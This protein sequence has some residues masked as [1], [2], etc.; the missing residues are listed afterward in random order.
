MV[1]NKQQ[2]QRQRQHQQ[3]QYKTLNNDICI[4]NLDL[5]LPENPRTNICTLV[6]GCIEKKQTNKQTQNK[7]LYINNTNNQNN[8]KNPLIRFSL[9]LKKK[10]HNPTQH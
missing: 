5:R 1:I 2:R 3:Q 4:Q 8:S 10:K 6:H 7:A 9:S